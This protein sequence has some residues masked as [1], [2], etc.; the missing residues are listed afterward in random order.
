MS[1][2]SSSSL[3]LLT[4][5]FPLYGGYYDNKP[6][7]VVIGIRMVTGNRISCSF[8]IILKDV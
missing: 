2:Y 8:Y 1:Q 3:M 6:S 4:L 7:K 5:T